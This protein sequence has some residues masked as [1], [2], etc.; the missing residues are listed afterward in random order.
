M[1]RATQV[2]IVHSVF[3]GYRD[4]DEYTRMNTGFSY[5]C[6]SVSICSLSPFW[7]WLVRVREVAAW[8]TTK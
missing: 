4:L 2:P 1:Q 3:F 6:V 5:L 8:I 7:L